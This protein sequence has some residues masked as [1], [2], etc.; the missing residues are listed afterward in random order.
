MWRSL[1]SSCPSLFICFYCCFDGCC[2]AFSHTW[3]GLFMPTIYAQNNHSM[4]STIVFSFSIDDTLV[5]VNVH[6]MFSGY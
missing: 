4:F 5:A 2:S 6:V 3:V 1:G